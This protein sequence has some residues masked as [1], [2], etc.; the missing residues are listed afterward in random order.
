M[1]EPMNVV[2]V[3]EEEDY[4]PVLKQELSVVSSEFILSNSLSL[5]R[6]CDANVKN[7]MKI[8][9]ICWH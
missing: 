3:R 2:H 5:P 6:V 9:Q 7:E 1:D 8:I 4:E